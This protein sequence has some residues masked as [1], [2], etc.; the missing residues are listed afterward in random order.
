MKL[1]GVTADQ[2]DFM[3]FH[4]ANIRIIQYI[5]KKFNV[6]DEKNIINIQRYGNT[7]A[8]TIPIAFTEA[9]ASGR[10][11][12]GNIVAFSVFGGGLTWGG[13]VVRV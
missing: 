1:A 7:S 10:I 2:V 13:A 5:A 6:P 9:I 3:I 11:K 8:A 12:K 4:Q